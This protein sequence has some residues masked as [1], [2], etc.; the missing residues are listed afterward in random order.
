MVVCLQNAATEAVAVVLADLPADA[1]GEE[2]CGGPSVAVTAA[3]KAEVALP[4]LGVAW[5]R[6]PLG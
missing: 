3:G 4:P 2:L 1:V 5:L 6:F